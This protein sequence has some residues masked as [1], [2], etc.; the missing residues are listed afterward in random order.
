MFTPSASADPGNPEVVNTICSTW[1]STSGICD[2]YNFADDETSS[3]EWMEGRY[4]IHMANATIMT[5]TMELA[6][7]EISRADVYLEDLPLGNGSDASSDGIPADYLRNYF[8]YMTPAGVDVQ[9]ALRSEISSTASSLIDNGF[10]TTAGVVTQYVNQITIE[11]QNIQCTDDQ[12][13]DSADEVAGLPNDA[14]DPPICLSTTL[15]ISVNPA[16]LGMTAV[17]LD[18]ERAY[19]GLLTMGGTVTTEIN[20]T[21]LPGHYSSY[22]FIPPNYGT[23]SAVDGN[24]ETFPATQGGYDYNYARWSVDNRDTTGDEWLNQSASITMARRAT[25]TKAVEL[26]LGNDLGVEI[27]I[28]IDAS[29]EQATQVSMI[30]GIR[31][32]GMDALSNWDWDY[33]DERVSVPWVTSDGLRLAHHSGL[34]NLNDFADSIPVDELN[35]VVATYSPTEIIFPSFEFTPANASGGLDFMHSPASTCAEGAPSYWC[36]QGGTAMNGTYPV[37]L[38]TQSNPFDLDII[39]LINSLADDFGVDLRGFDPEILTVEDRAALLNSGRFSGSLPT[40]LLT[41]WMS[42][43][44]PSADITLNIMLPSWIRSGDGSPEVITIRHSTT[45]SGNSSQDLTLMGSNPYDWRHSICQTSNQCDDSTLDF[46]CGDNRRTCIAVNLDID[47]KSLDIHEWS[48]SI[49]MDVETEIELLI[50]RIG[51]PES[52]LEGQDVVEIEAIPSDLIRRIIS[53]GDGIDG[54]LLAPI[55][56]NLSVQI[57]DEN[58]PIT[59]NENGIYDFADRIEDIIED[60]M[61]EEMQSTLDQQQTEDAPIRMSSERIEVRTSVDGLELAPGSSLSDTRPI[62]ITMEIDCPAITAEWLGDGGGGA[63]NAL[64]SFA[65]MMKSVSSFKH[66]AASGQISGIDLPGEVEETIEPIVEEEEG[67][68]VTP[69]ASIRVTFPRGL[70]FSFFESDLNRAS[71]TESNGRQTL[72]YYLP[73]CTA[74]DVDDCSDESDTI[75]FAFVVGWEYIFWQLSAYIFGLLG[76]IMLLFYIRRRRKGNRKKALLEK[77]RSRDNKGLFFSDGQLHIRDENMLDDELY[78][79]DGL[80]DMGSLPGLDSK[81]NIS[82][83]SWDE[84]YADLLKYDD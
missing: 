8:E 36:I 19:Q 75:R 6:I 56:E 78:G 16:N 80:P 31:H 35:D 65:R 25:L 34:A 42:E 82:G 2:D 74:N 13:A 59:L 11:G 38:A 15:S 49:V 60:R 55:D 62:R 58:I 32:I 22:E 45:S 7:H 81:G 41:N 61:N 4:S 21:A 79:D 14:Y 73:V 70:G 12:N 57:E 37:Y 68:V 5:V 46:V 18:V 76:L 64:T 40:N 17:G 50:Y 77:E 48:K 26:D 27:E 3:D 84:D 28:V 10:G 52:I 83:E 47:I 20:L 53:I 66:P 29:V 43:D 24:G 9:E 23:V 30:M 1:N 69:A 63:T 33:V 54:G 51:V 71:L 39:Q 67:E 72:T 44:L